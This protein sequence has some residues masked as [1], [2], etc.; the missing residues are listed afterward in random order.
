M[1]SL[2]FIYDLTDKL[3][4]DKIAYV[5]VALQEGATSDKVDVFYHVKDR[6]TKKSMLAVLQRLQHDITVDCQIGDGDED[7]DDPI[8]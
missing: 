1:A 6:T 3:E 2:D 5:V 4:D 8:F 7:E